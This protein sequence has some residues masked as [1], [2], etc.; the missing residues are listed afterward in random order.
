MLVGHYDF[1][2]VSLYHQRIK[3]YK[4]QGISQFPHQEVRDIKD[5]RSCKYIEK[6][7]GER[8]SPYRTPMLQ[9]NESESASPVNDTI[10]FDFIY[11]FLSH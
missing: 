8:F 4:V 9:R 5:F 6:R 1:E 11:M 10:Y 3:V 2:L 7:S